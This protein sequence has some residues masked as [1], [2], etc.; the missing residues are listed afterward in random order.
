MLSIHLPQFRCTTSFAMSEKKLSSRNVSWYL[1]PKIN[2]N[3]YQLK[4]ETLSRRHVHQ[5]IESNN[6]TR[7]LSITTK[8][9]IL[10]ILIVIRRSC[11][12][13]HYCI[14]SCLRHLHNRARNPKRSEFDG[15]CHASLSLSFCYTF[16]IF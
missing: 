9:C 6:D 12:S 2:I 5:V 14:D 3:T 16:Y 11:A 15:H 7:R 1:F 13:V 8:I 10:L 4:S